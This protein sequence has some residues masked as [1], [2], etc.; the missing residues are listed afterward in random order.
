MFTLLIDL[1]DSI[2][3]LHRS[4]FSCRAHA[5]SFLQNRPTSMEGTAGAGL[6]ASE[7]LKSGRVVGQQVVREHALPHAAPQRSKCQPDV[8]VERQGQ[9]QAEEKRQAEERLTLKEA[10][11]TIRKMEKDLQRLREKN[12]QLTKSSA[13]NQRMANRKDFLKRDRI[14]KEVEVETKERLMSEFIQP[15]LHQLRLEQESVRQQRSSV[16]EPCQWFD[17]VVGGFDQQDAALCR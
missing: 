3:L 14:V 13:H 15:E 10:E 1:V 11:K 16:K 5:C 7:V 6:F 2:F 8:Q 12:S 9:R 17:R 4:Y